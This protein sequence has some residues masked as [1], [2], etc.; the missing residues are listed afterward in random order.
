MS[1]RKVTAYRLSAWQRKNQREQLKC[2]QQ[3]FACVEQIKSIVSNLLGFGGQIETLLNTLAFI[4]ERTED[5]S[6]EINELQNIQVDLQQECNLFLDE[7]SANMP[8]ASGRIKINDDELNEKKILLNKLK[9]IQAK[10]I[11]YNNEI[12][13]T[14]SK[15]NAKA[16]SYIGEV[17]S[18]IANDI[19]AVTSFYIDSDEIDEEPY[20]NTRKNLENKL[21]SLSMSD[22]CPKSIKPKILKALTSL[23]RITNNEY[24]NAFDAVTIKPLLEKYN[25]QV[26]KNR[27]KRDSFAE[28]IARY[29]ALCTITQTQPK[30]FSSDDIDIE[31]ITSAIAVLEKQIV[32][33]TEQ[34][35]ISDCLNDVM[36]EMGYDLIGNR[37][38]TKSS[39]KRFKNELFS[40][41][42][43]TAINVTYDSEGQIAMELCGIDRTDRVPTS[44]ET[45]A[46]CKDMESFCAD[47]VVFEEKLKEKGVF[48]ESRIS[49]SPPVAEYASIINLEDY[50][51]TTTKP[52]S[53]IVTKNKRRRSTTKQMLRR[54]N[55]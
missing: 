22:D 37:S 5:C 29:K 2:T 30:D 48:V 18:G 13:Q 40:Y 34:E 24:L 36:I 17:K 32:T 19:A 23:E 11:S 14:F 25:E 52:V 9:T 41:D 28:T 49:M 43:G 47:F 21:R 51:I 7:L 26:A 46:L 53:E 55:N 39:G 31:S 38:V 4:N 35:Y 27:D 44:D 50:N 6:I 15:I 54:E 20:A 1:G 12:E 33:Q 16:Q 8:A 3:S 10:A 42:D 45:D